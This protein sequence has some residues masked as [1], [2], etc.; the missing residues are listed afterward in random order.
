MQRNGGGSGC[1]AEWAIERVL[2]NPEIS[3]LRFNSQGLF[4][5]SARL[6]ADGVLADFRRVD[7]SR[8]FGGG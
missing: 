7:L 3:R 2:N 1:L 8:S 5:F 4:F 6:D